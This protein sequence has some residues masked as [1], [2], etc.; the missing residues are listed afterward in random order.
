MPRS[1]DSLSTAPVYAQAPARRRTLG[2]LFGTLFI[3][4][5]A[6][7]CG[8]PSTEAPAAPEAPSAERAAAEP[9]FSPEQLQ[10]D[11]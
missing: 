11:L 2:A 6:V 8:P 1:I 4:L 3:A 9:T 5:L 7:G 10:E